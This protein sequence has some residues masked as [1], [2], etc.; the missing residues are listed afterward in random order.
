MAI[1]V[2]LW[3]GPYKSIRVWYD[4]HIGE[5][6]QYVWFSVFLDF[7][8][9]GKFAASIDRPKAKSVSAS[10]GIRPLTPGPFQGLYPWT[11]LGLRPQ[12]PVIG[13]RSALAMVCPHFLI[14]RSAVSG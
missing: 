12:T 8:K 7:R 6:T 14:F 10:G 9:V 13:S 1:G 11:P 5:I 2:G 3:A 4:G